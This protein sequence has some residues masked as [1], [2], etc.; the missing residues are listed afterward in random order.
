MR[1]LTSS[2]LLLAI[3]TVPMQAQTYDPRYPVCMK[4]YDAA[5]GGGERYDCSFTSLPQCRATASGRPA[6]CELNPYFARA[7][8]RRDGTYRRHQQIY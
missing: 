8:A 4:V 2:V 6:M 1:V 3:M 5:F 7:Q